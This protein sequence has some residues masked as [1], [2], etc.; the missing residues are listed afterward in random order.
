MRDGVV[1]AIEDSVDGGGERGG[2]GFRASGEDGGP[3]GFEEDV[4]DTGVSVEEDGDA[5]LEGLDGGDSVALDGGHEEEMGLIVEGLEFGVGD[6][7]VEVDAVAEA[8]L[9]G[10]FAERGKLRAGACNVERQSV[11]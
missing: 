7:A 4:G 3:G 6:E 8:E 2:E 11:H 5:A 1:A 10:E 9:G